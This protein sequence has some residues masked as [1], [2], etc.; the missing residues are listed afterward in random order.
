LVVEEAGREKLLGTFV[1]LRVRCMKTAL[2]FYTGT[3]NSLWTARTLAAKLGDA[4]IHPIS[5]TDGGPLPGRVEAVGLVFPVHIWGVPGRVID[6]V[7]SLANAPSCYYFAVAVHAG[8]VAATLLQL[9]RLLKSKGISLSC[10]FEIA[11]PSN[12]IPW[13]G[14]G[15]QEKRARRYEEAGRKIERIAGLVSRREEGPVEKGPLWQNILFTVLN[16]LSFSRVPR[17]DKGFW[18]DGKCNACGICGT[19]CPCGNIDLVEGRPVWRHRCEQC[20]ACIQW[21]PAEAIQYG[22]KTSGYERY[23]HPEVTLREML[24]VAAIRENQDG[25]KG[26]MEDAVRI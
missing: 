4:E 18:V 5:A 26:E 7:N 21:C 3:G 2:F 20:L 6:F 22:R 15:P 23:R 1:R 12:Y 13:G 25:T 24:A 9:E 16:R 19:I 11:M 8:Q 17:L 14:P 10:G